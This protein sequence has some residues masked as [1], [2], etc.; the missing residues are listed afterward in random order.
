MTN[1]LAKA[2]EKASELPEDIQNQLARE[3]LE[4]MEGEA[5]WNSTLTS[6]QEKL[7]RLADEAERQFRDGKTKEMGFDEL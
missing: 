3:M 2:F 6:S 7:E 4:E 5:R 1:L